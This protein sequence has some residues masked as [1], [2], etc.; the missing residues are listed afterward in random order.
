[1]LSELFPEQLA[2][3]RTTLALS[4]P[5]NGERMEKNRKKQFISHYVSSGWHCKAGESC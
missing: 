2:G 5:G 1:M 3:G 4:K